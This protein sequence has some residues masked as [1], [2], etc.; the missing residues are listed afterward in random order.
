[1]CIDIHAYIY[2]PIYIYIS[3]I[4]RSLGPQSLKTV[5]PSPRAFGNLHVT[6]CGLGPR[7]QKTFF[8]GA[9][10][11]DNFSVVVVIES[12]IWVYRAPSSG[13]GY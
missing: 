13:C 11:M 5:V 4:L 3:T 1:M 12:E 9:E 2:I 7:E 8:K 6:V 10:E